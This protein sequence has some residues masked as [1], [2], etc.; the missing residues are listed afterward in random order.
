MLGKGT[1]FRLSTGTKRHLP[2]TLIYFFRLALELF[3][4]MSIHLDFRA[5][6][7]ARLRAGAVHYFCKLDSRV[8]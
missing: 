1:P 2:W 4:F 5:G 8:G 3:G 6:S 7:D